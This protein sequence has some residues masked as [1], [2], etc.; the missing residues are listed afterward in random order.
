MFGEA[1]RARFALASMW[2]PDLRST[3]R[4]RAMCYAE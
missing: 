3:A 2:G 4:D 1:G